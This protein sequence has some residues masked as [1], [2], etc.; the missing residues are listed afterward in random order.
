MFLV[1]K[2]K[3]YPTAKANISCRYLFFLHK[4]NC[5][6]YY[7]HKQVLALSESILYKQNSSTNFRC[8]DNTNGDMNYNA[9]QEFLKLFLCLCRTVQ[10]ES[11]TLN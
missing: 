8:L 6:M 9:A 3:Y 4:K 5:D 7:I 11:D 10:C 1:G 2:A